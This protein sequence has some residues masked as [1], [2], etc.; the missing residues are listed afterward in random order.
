MILTTYHNLEPRLRISGYT[1][2][3]HLYTLMVWTGTTVFFNFAYIL[4]VSVTS[5]H[6]VP[7]VTDM[8]AVI[9]KSTRKCAEQT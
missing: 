3:L 5:G 7:T 6:F 2:L 8:E 4:Y 1:P 9:H